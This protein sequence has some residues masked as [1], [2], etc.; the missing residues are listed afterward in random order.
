MVESCAV[1]NITPSFCSG[2]PY[3]ARLWL[4]NNGI[5]TLPEEIGQLVNLET[6]LAGLGERNA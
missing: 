2:L 4:T 6:W 5:K 1:P 3:L